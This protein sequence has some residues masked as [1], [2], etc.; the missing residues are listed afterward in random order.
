M[1]SVRAPGECHAC[2]LTEP[3]AL[4][5]LI[6]THPLR[7]SDSRHSNG[8]SEPLASSSARPPGGHST[9]PPKPSSPV[10]P[11]PPP[12]PRN[13]VQNGGSEMVGYAKPQKKSTSHATVT[14]TPSRSSQHDRPLDISDLDPIESFLHSPRLRRLIMENYHPAPEYAE[15]KRA[16]RIDAI[17]GKIDMN[18]AS[19]SLSRQQKND[20]INAA[21][22]EYAAHFTRSRHSSSSKIKENSSNAAV[23][24]Y[25]LVDVNG[26]ASVDAVPTLAKA[27]TS[28]GGLKVNITEPSP[29]ESSGSLNNSF[30]KRPSN[31]TSPSPST[32]GR[33]K[34]SV[35]LIHKKLSD[36]QVQTYDIPPGGEAKKPAGLAVVTT[37]LRKERFAGCGWGPRLPLGFLIAGYALLILLAIVIG[38][39]MMHLPNQ[40]PASRSPVSRDLS[41]DSEGASSLSQRERLQVP[42]HQPKLITASF[43][44]G[45]QNLDQTTGRSRALDQ[46]DAAVFSNH[47]DHFDS[48]NV[49]DPTIQSGHID[50]L[51]VD[52]SQQDPFS[53]IENN[54]VTPRIRSGEQ[55]HGRPVSDTNSLRSETNGFVMDSVGDRSIPIN[56]GD[57]RRNNLNIHANPSRN[58]PSLGLTPRP[59]LTPDQ[60]SDRSKSVSDASAIHNAIKNVDLSNVRQT[61]NAQVIDFTGSNR[62]SIPP[63]STGPHKGE[64]NSVTDPRLSS[65]KSFSFNSIPE[66]KIIRSWSNSN[67]DGTFSYGYLN[68]DGS[69]KNETRGHDCVVHGVYG[70][71]DPETGVTL[72]FPYQSG[73]PCPPRVP[74]A[75]HDQVRQVGAGV[76]NALTNTIPPPTFPPPLPVHTHVPQQQLQHVQLQNRARQQQP[77]FGQRARQQQQFSNIPS[78]SDTFPVDN[79]ANRLSLPQEHQSSIAHSA[80]RHEE[81]LKQHAQQRDQLHSEQL[82]LHQTQ[83][84]AHLQLVEKQNQREKSQLRP[85]I[86]EAKMQE[87][88]FIP[89]TASDHLR[90][91]QELQRHV[92]Q[93]Q[94]LLS[95]Q[96]T[97]KRAREN[98]R[99]NILSQLRAIAADQNQPLRGT[100]DGV[101]KN[102]ALLQRENNN[103]QILDNDRF[104]QQLQI[105]AQQDLLT[106]QQSAQRQQQLN[107]IEQQKNLF[108][109]LQQQHQ[110]LRAQP[111]VANVPLRQ[112][113]PH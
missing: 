6:R 84:Q 100:N 78:T 85:T 86:V 77:N 71:V 53:L 98:L 50:S 42:G 15:L 110:R 26:S 17:V 90:R 22:A 61:P 112:D 8:R 9:L 5:E 35:T 23:S 30:I 65:D 7:T 109:Q 91:Q 64:V 48:N 25:D 38:V 59:V 82:R 83:L 31:V 97:D 87:H 99:E 58:D 28:N 67:P 32:L 21:R 95:Q 43:D 36:A 73:N 55:A 12:P 57:Q 40:R 92:Q 74:Q 10:P 66:A 81:A 2:H 33:G 18:Q 13:P 80:L 54:F 44:G 105:Q 1:P 96:Q 88:H 52:E 20:K 69:F 93:K 56:S 46:T 75:S 63:R 3:I 68:T 37:L 29:S 62:V 108:R 14:K 113:Q 16:K 72:S 51:L 76:H 34:K 70:Y 19:K 103:A 41:S 107:Q 24:H 102:R 45:F 49:H 47:V 106:K 94:E 39:S 4:A 27:A 11:P 60:F 101:Q 104:Q 89:H 79:G 111:S